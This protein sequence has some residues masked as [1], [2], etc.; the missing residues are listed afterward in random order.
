MG[1][2]SAASATAAGLVLKLPAA[3]NS[4]NAATTVAPQKVQ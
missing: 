1:L 3:T 2:N 4:R